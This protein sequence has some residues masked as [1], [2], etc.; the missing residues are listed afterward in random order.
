MTQ[1][2]ITCT[3]IVAKWLPLALWLA[4]TY[5]PARY[6]M[7]VAPWLLVRACVVG[8]VTGL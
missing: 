3:I 8:K 4:R 2:Q 5:F 6:Y 1:P 7:R